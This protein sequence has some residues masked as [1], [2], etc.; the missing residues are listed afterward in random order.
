MA[1]RNR[2]L[3]A[4]LTPGQQ[5][6]VQQLL[7]EQQ[8]QASWHGGVP[9]LV[10]ERCWLRLRATPVEQLAR[11]L[12]PDST[13]EAPELVR[14]RELR[15]Q[16]LSEGAAQAHC[17]EEFGPAACQLALR[18]HWQALEGPHHGWTLDAY[19]TFLRT[20]R[21]RFAAGQERPLPLLVLG[22][23][24]SQEPHRIHWLVETGA[25]DAAHLPPD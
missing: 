8:G 9:V 20:Y 4:W 25:L 1:D 18:R 19:L 15:Q 22:R 21:A 17:W 10:L 16:G 6:R 11:L 13:A 5:A 3:I 7:A 12:P 24:G 2:E 23:R 14:F